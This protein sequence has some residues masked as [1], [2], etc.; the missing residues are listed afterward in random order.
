MKKKQLWKVLGTGVL[1]LSLMLSPMTG[2][3]VLAA[4]GDPVTPAAGSKEGIDPTVADYADTEIPVYGFTESNVV[5]SVDVEWGAMTFQYV[6][7]TWDPVTHQYAE[8]AGW[9]VY[10][11]TNDTAVEGTEDAINEIK[12][13]NHSNAGVKATFSYANKTDYSDI[14]GAFSSTKSTLTAATETEPASLELATADNNKGT[15]DGQGEAV[16]GQVYFMPTGIST[17]HKA[18]GIEKWATIGT[19]TVGIKTAEAAAPTEP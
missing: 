9:K 2:L 12:V 18:D 1:A 4:E 13:T 5:Y 14:S 17:A 8:D 7:G 15:E 6:S 11:S 19:I 10:D 16:V 3:G